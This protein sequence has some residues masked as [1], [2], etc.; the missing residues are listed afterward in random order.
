[1]E[2]IFL[3]VGEAAK[4]LAVS[5]WSVWQSLRLGKLSAR[6]YGRKTLI[7]VASLKACADALPIAEFGTQRIA[8]PLETKPKRRYRRRVLGGENG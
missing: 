2:P 1:M 6:K 5:K 4:V 7:E 3:S 8:V